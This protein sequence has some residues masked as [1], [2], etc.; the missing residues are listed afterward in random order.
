[1]ATIITIVPL[2]IPLGG[3]AVEFDWGTDCVVWLIVETGMTLRNRL[4]EAYW[5]R[6]GRDP[7][8]IPV[9]LSLLY[10]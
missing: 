3:A 2:L 5:L 10:P 9:N 8:G 6:G 7:F 1:M 4:F